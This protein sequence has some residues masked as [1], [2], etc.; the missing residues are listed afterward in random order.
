MNKISIIGSTGSIGTKA[1]DICLEKGIEVVSL[2]AYSNYKLLSE[3][4]RKLSVK[5]VCIYNERYY[6]DLKTLLGDTNVNVLTGESGLLEI[7][8]D[9]SDMLLNSVVGMIGLKPTLEA[10]NCGKNIALANKETLVAGGKLVMDAVKRKKVKMIP[11]DSEHSA[12]YQCLLGHNKNELNKIILTASGGPFFAKTKKELENVRVEDALNHPNW[13]MGSKITIDSATLMNKGFEVIEASW[14]FDIDIDKIDVVVHR[15]SIIHS[16]I[17]LN[18]RSIIA[19]LGVPDMRIPIQLALTYP[20]RC[21]CTVKPF[22]FTEYPALTFYKPDRKT[23]KSLDICIN[24]F[25]KGGLYPAA[26]NAANEEAVAQFLGNNCRFNDITD[27]I[28][29]ATS[30]LDLDIEYNLDN[31]YAITEEARRIVRESL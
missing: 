9:E 13:S 8:A 26:V 19:E 23:F 30:R 12:I 1:V 20:D 24:A 29:S 4:A 25:K 7:S 28:E 11:V 21:D 14:L 3:Q 31:I 22:N 27:L 16:M 17:E 10:I 2:A 6:N 15:E 18:D 5:N